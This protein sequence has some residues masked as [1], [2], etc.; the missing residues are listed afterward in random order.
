MTNFRYQSFIPKEDYKI[1]PRLLVKYLYDIIEKNINN[2]IY[3]NNKNIINII[4]KEMENIN[5]SYNVL[6]YKFCMYQYSDRNNN[7]NITRIYS[8][9]IDSEHITLCAKHNYNHIS[10]SIKINE[11]NECNRCPIIKK[12]GE[13]CKYEFSIEGICVKH[14]KFKNNI[15]NVKEIYNFSN[16]EFDYIL[17]LKIKESKKETNIS[18]DSKINKFLKYKKNNKNNINLKNNDEGILSNYENT[19]IIKN[20]KKEKK[21]IYIQ[22]DFNFIT[23]KQCKYKVCSNHKYYINIP[24]PPGYI[25]SNLKNVTNFLKKENLCLHN[26][27][28]V[29]C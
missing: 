18:N 4:Y 14:Y 13:Q 10:K 17:D 9:K 20:N 28:C 1:R 29:T 8:K 6:S 22:K 27:F 15:K 11:I 24:Y 16:I 7:N 5:F 12:N 3:E 23:I 19:E 2:E 25:S 26:N 21:Q